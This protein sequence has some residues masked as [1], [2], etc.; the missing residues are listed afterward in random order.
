[1]AVDS[2]GCLFATQTGSVA[3]ITPPGP[4][5]DL[6]PTT[7]GA[8]PPPG[9]VIETVAGAG[10]ETVK[11][12]K[13]VVRRRLVVR[14]RQ[15]GRVRL[16]VVRVYVKGKHRKTLRHRRISAPIVI[17]HVPRG[18]F[19][20]KLVARTMHGRKLTARKRFRNCTRGRTA[21]RS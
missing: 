16:R 21:A 11:G 15:R 2:H 10:G 3:R 14:V 13:C 18:K 4:G 19:T 20:V 5:C 1:V 17:R 12:G 7:P 9:I 6:A 8:V